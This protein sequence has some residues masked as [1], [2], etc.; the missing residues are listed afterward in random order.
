M[1][2]TAPVGFTITVTNVN[3]NDAPDDVIAVGAN[4]SI[5]IPW[6]ARSGGD[7]V[8]SRSRCDARLRIEGSTEITRQ[9]IATAVG[10]NYR[11]VTNDEQ[12]IAIQAIL[13]N[14]ITAILT[15][16]KPQLETI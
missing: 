11:N 8:N 4:R 16:L 2:L 12:S 5:T 9:E 1:I 15:A 10:K 3:I 14:E 13:Q 6:V 7:T